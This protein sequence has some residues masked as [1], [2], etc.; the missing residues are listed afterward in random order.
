MSEIKIEEITRI[1]LD[2]D[3][4]LLVRLPDDADQ[5]Q[6]DQVRK[7]ILNFFKI[8]PDRLLMYSGEVEFKKVKP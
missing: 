2:R 4:K 1:K 6:F 7:S 3:E 5:E 8:T